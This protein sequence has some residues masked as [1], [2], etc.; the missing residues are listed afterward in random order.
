[1]TIIYHEDFLKL[2][3]TMGHPEC[4]ERLSSILSYLETNDVDVGIVKPE[5]A[6]RD[7]VE[8]VHTAEYLDFLRDFGEGHMDMDSYIW[9]HTYDMAM[10]SAGGG[11][12]A[13]EQAFEKGEP[14][15]ALLRPPGHHAAE[16]RG[17]G[18]C[19]IN[20][21]A[22]AASHLLKKVDKVAIVDVD[23]HHGNGTNDIFLDNDNVLFISTHQFGIFPGTGPAEQ[24]GE[25]AGEGYTVNVP[26]GSR[27]GD[28]TFLVAYRKIVK[29]ILEQYEPDIILVSLGLD[30]HYL[31]PLASLTLS[32][33]GFMEILTLLNDLAGE[34]CQG[35]IAFY[36]EGGYNLHALADV[37]GCAISQFHGGGL[38]TRYNEV[39]DMDGL[40]LDRVKHALGIQKKYWDV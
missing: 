39:Q 28:G 27:T 30:A 12:N 35:R 5:P 10:L 16:Y 20:N 15:F 38:S 4:P 29:P 37:V 21:I 34:Q 33:R 40:G 25:G 19:Y 22:V 23:V 9:P 3:Q 32:S 2:T 24:V 8:A 1:M 11:L 6:A 17:C 14:A 36:L 31:D 7:V 13:A 26:F 18:F